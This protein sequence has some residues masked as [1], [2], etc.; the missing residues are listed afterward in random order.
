M[1]AAR[2][3]RIARSLAAPTRCGLLGLLF[4]A[5]GLLGALGGRRGVQGP[6]RPLHR[7]QKGL[8]LLR[9]LPRR[10]CAC[11]AEPAGAR[12]RRPTPACG[13]PATPAAAPAQRRKTGPP[14]AG[15]MPAAAAPAPPPAPMPTAPAAAMPAPRPRRAAAAA[16]P[17]SAAAA[18][19]AAHGAWATSALVRTP[20]A[21]ETPAHRASAAAPQPP[22]PALYD[23]TCPDCDYGICG[24]YPDGCGGTL[25]CGACSACLDDEDGKRV[26]QSGAPC[27]TSSR[28]PSSSMHE[29]PTTRTRRRRSPTVGS[30]QN[31][32]SG[33]GRFSSRREVL[34]GDAP[35]R[36]TRSP[37]PHPA[38]KWSPDLPASYSG[39]SGTT[40][41]LNALPRAFPAPPPFPPW[42]PIPG[43]VPSPGQEGAPSSRSP[44]GGRETEQP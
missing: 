42:N 29:G 32:P 4:G 18:R 40:F 19:P 28:S 1:D 36:A 44:R 15:A 2:F 21:A 24:P 22:A 6:R 13:P 38:T 34:G 12:C 25:N 41:S 31:A 14:A 7:R 10:E 43:P 27:G 5:G 33:L 11:A 9:S 26:Y 39:P 37:R 30:W 17:A 23:D 35:E 8:L 20:A 3:D 16:R